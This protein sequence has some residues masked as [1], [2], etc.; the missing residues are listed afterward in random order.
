VPRIPGHERGAKIRRNVT[1]GQCL[2]YT[3]D[4]EIFLKIMMVI[5]NP[6]PTYFA[7]TVF[8]KIIRLILEIDE[9]GNRL[10]ILAATCNRG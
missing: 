1:S 9:Y 10:P 2:L 3:L 4:L 8:A 6:M 5:L 7:F